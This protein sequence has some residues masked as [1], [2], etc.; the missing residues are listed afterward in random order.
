MIGSS[1]V[2][3][4]SEIAAHSLRPGQRLDYYSPL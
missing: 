2:I 1:I 4:R 3:A